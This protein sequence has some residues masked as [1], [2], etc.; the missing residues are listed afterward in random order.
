MNNSQI[1]LLFHRLFLLAPTSGTTSLERENFLK[2]MRHLLEATLFT[3]NFA[4]HSSKKQQKILKNHQLSILVS[5]L[6]LRSESRFSAFVR[7]PH[8]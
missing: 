1:V 5:H 2:K 8:F 7:F 4:A 3:K 6:S